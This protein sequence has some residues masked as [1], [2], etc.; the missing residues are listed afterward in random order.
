MST[1]RSVFRRLAADPGYALAFVVTLGL[2][3]GATTAIFSGIEGILIRPLPYP[4]ADR[5]VYV[6]Q[7]M[8][9]RGGANANFSFVEVQDYRQQASSIE[10]LVEYGDWQFNVVGQGEPM[11]AYGGLV[12]SNYFKVLNIRAAQGRTLVADDDRAGAAPVAVL[13]HEFWRDRFGSD[14][15]A[16][17]RVIELS[18]IATT[19][20]GVLEPGS[21]YAG[22]ERAEL[23]AN[24]PTNAHYMSASMQEE[25]SHRMTDVYALL[26]PGVAKERAEIEM[27][28]VLDR[29]RA[30]H[31]SDYPETAGIAMRLTP[32]RDVLVR[33]ARPTFLILMGAVALVLIVACANV[34]NL[35][36][37]RL[38]RRERELAVR[39]ALGASPGRLRREL[40]A[41]HLLLAG[42]GSLVGIVIAAVAMNQL[43][44]YAARM[45]LRSEEIR[46]NPVVLAFALGTGAAIAVLLAWAPR[47]PGLTGAAGTLA[48]ASTGS[49]LTGGRGQRRAQRLLVAG[50]VAVSFVVLVGAALLA[51]SLMNLQRVET[52][53]RAD[54]VVALRT[55][56]FTRATPVRNRAM[57]DEL[58][59]RL[60]SFAGVQ[61][62]AVASNVPFGISSVSTWQLR[63]EGRSPETLEAP[64]QMLPSV[65]SPSYF[66]A[67]GIAVLRGRAF[68]ATDHATA[69]RAVV[70][71]EALAALAFGEGNPIG[72][73]V[74]WSFDGTTWP[75]WRTV[76]GVARNARELGPHKPPIPTV[77]E[78]SLQA[79]PG[80]G[81]LIRTAGDPGPAA[82]EAARLVHEMDPKRPVTDVR[83]LDSARDEHVAP[84]RLNAS[85]FAALA[86]VAVSIAAV[87]LAGV[88]A[89]AVSERT[90]EFGI[91]MALGAEPGAI[92]R[93]VI[94]EGLSMAALGLA[95]GLAAALALTRFVEGILFD[96][97]PTHPPTLLA[98]AVLVI[99]LAVTAAWLPARRATMVPPTEALRAE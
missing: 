52:G 64:F 59:T 84:S 40:L 27:Q 60:Q 3:I 17:G 1:L 82:R 79:N 74:Q 12:T 94:G 26:R 66:D 4:H 11:L 48:S 95:V 39:A 96:V 88:L 44:S 35:T 98:G 36:L 13:T 92:R 51:R 63:V 77:Y 25:R 73:R 69:D 22:S 19:V 20:V 8:L 15:G 99:G 54:S 67:L 14:P 16:V 32:W 70:L 78:S 7:P 45:T 28:A 31:P 83:M 2:G 30:T 85:L 21:H 18:G 97:A 91:R 68:D 56:N 5:I 80:P 49:R 87:G 41:E 62:V 55:P 81:V 43:V 57:F 75:G 47:L 46:L 37:A 58:T 9:R 50:Q 61:A 76:V 89:F 6:E 10:E 23:Y 33:D 38:V 72:R 71:N 24:Y 65:V 86:I 90:R 93:G 29:L 53:L 42:A 34:G